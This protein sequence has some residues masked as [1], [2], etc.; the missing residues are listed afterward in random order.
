MT[1]GIHGTLVSLDVDL[2]PVELAG[3]PDGEPLPIAI[4]S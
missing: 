1:G 2:S 4:A 3:A